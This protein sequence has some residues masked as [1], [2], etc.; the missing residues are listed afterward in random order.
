[1]IRRRTWKRP[2][3]FEDTEAIP[4]ALRTKPHDEHESGM[5]I[6]Y[7]SVTTLR[8]D[9]FDLAVEIVRVRNYLGT[10]CQS[11]YQIRLV[12]YGA[13]ADQKIAL[14]VSYRPGDPHTDTYGILRVLLEDAAKYVE[15]L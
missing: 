2:R 3:T 10:D 11:H 6:S 5:R 15:E 7:E 1:M 14:N 4:P 8:S 13:H 9:S 12:G